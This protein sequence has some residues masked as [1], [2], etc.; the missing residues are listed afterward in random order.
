MLSSLSLAVAG[1]LCLAQAPRSQTTLLSGAAAGAAPYTG[2][3]NIV[4][5]AKFWG[6]LRAYTSSLCTGTT[7]AIDVVDTATGLTTTTINI[8]TNCYLDNA[9]VLAL[10][11]GVSVTK[12]YDQTGN[13]N[14][15]VSTTLSRMPILTQNQINTFPAMTFTVGSNHLLNSGATPSSTSQPFSISA[16]ARRTASVQNSR[17]LIG[18][19]IG[20]YLSSTT[21]N[22][23][24]YAGNQNPV[25]GATEGT[26]H[27]LQGTFNG[28]SSIGS[29]NGS[30]TTIDAG[31]TAISGDFIVG[32]DTLTGGIVEL[33]LWPS[34]F[35]TGNNTSMS[36]NQRSAYGGGW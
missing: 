15:L 33:G 2:P 20:L 11:Y 28:A 14:F 21:D 4:A 16:V 1:C 35:T 9:A 32:D 10:G 34:G 25:A 6:G 36:A 13:S 27:A 23:L 7:P 29:V 22:L 5:G 3:G 26:Y 17:I 18:S 12:L 31:T 8:A 24:V 30:S 19:T